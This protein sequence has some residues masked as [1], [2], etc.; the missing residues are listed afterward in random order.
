MNFK[1]LVFSAVV[2]SSLAGYS[3]LPQIA[4]KIV[5]QRWPWSPKVDVCFTVARGGDDS[6]YN[7]YLKA[8][9]FK[10]PVFVRALFNP[11]GVYHFEWDPTEHGFESHQLKNLEVQFTPVPVAQHQFLTVWLTNTTVN[12]VTHKAG[13]VQW[14]DSAPNVPSSQSTEQRRLTFRRVN[15]GRGS[16]TYTNGYSTALSEKPLPGKDGGTIKLKDVN[17][18]ATRLKEVRFSSDY[19]IEITQIMNGSAWKTCMN[20]DKKCSDQFST[21]TFNTFYG[22][23]TVRYTYAQ[24]RGSVS[25]GVNW[26]VTGFNVAPTSYVGQVRAWFKKMNVLPGCIVDLPTAAQWET[27][28]RA[29]TDGNQIFAPK[30]DAKG[31][32]PIT[33]DSTGLDFTNTLGNAYVDEDRLPEHVHKTTTGMTIWIY[34]RYAQ[35][36]TENGKKAD[37]SNAGRLDPNAWGIYDMGSMDAEFVLGQG[38]SGSDA[39][40]MDLFSGLDPV[41]C[42]DISPTA[43]RT[44]TRNGVSVTYPDAHYRMAFACHRS[45]TEGAYRYVPG[46]YYNYVPW[47]V[48]NFRLVINTENWTGVPLKE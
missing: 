16:I 18:N 6:D 37:N 31:Y 12:G 33:L 9:S 40:Y 45:S 7:V 23:N 19:F 8:D 27:A 25:A 14:L 5:R 15:S 30:A 39:R 46:V 13:E 42:R 47:D 21:A 4:D 35:G 22:C 38:L 11:R 10:E 28:A 41:G 24:I 44:G 34:N 17:G 43:T 32:G 48:A 26:P 29:G 3:A 36:H 1:N 20:L 2:L